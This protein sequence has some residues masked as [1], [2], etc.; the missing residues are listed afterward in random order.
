MLVKQDEHR[1]NLRFY[2]L[3]RPVTHTN[4]LEDVL[5]ILELLARSWRTTSAI[6]IMYPWLRISPDTIRMPIIRQLTFLSFC[7]RY[8]TSTRSHLG[9]QL[10][11]HCGIVLPILLKGVHD[12]SLT[13][14]LINSLQ[15]QIIQRC[16]QNHVFRSIIG[17]TKTIQVA[18]RRSGEFV[19]RVMHQWITVGDTSH[20][21]TVSIGFVSTQIGVEIA[22]FRHF[23]ST[24]FHF[25][26][27]ARLCLI[28]GYLHMIWVKVVNAIS[29][30]KFPCRLNI[31]QPTGTG[32]GTTR[33]LIL[34]TFVT[35]DIE[36][37][38]TIAIWID[39][40]TCFSHHTV[41]AIF[42]FKILT[43]RK[44]K[45]IA[46]INFILDFETVST[47]KV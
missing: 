43:I 17:I 23:F 18:G 26:A 21:R 32:A 12:T 44:L 25:P 7:Q 39:C 16:S 13:I 14:Y 36:C 15:L 30:S 42:L 11:L 38:I 24:F 40:L 47:I 22:C 19:I 41:H 31:P 34:P 46:Q 1:L 45:S 29:A 35:I 9:S 27:F 6:V 8:I 37:R 10:F 4:G 28:R 5:F 3:E 2:K 20:Y 33:Q